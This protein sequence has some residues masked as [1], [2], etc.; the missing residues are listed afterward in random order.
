MTQLMRHLALGALLIPLFAYTYDNAHFY[1]AT[2]FFFEPRLERDYL[3]SVDLFF[4]AGS[5][6]KARN[7]FHDTVPLLDIYGTNDMHELAI[8]VPCKDLSNPLDMIITQLSLVPS[9]CETS[10]DACKTQSKFATFSIDGT[11][12]I[13]EGIISIAQN[14]K[15]GFFLQLYFPIRRLKI[16]SICTTDIS[17]TDEACPN[18]N[19]PIW[20]TFK[21]NFDDILARYNL[22]RCP[23][24]KTGIGDITFLLGWTHSFQQ[25][26]VLDFVDT[27]FK[28]GVLIPS[29]DQRCEDQVFS[30]PIGYDG[31]VA[32]VIDA[33][34]A[35]GAFDWLT[36]GGHFDLLVFANKT[37]CIRLKTGE[38][39]SGWFKLAKG[40]TKREKG[41]LWQIGAY[42]KADHFAHGLS[43]LLAYS[44]ASKNRDELT[45]CDTQEFCPAIVNNDQMLFSWKMHTLNFLLE[46]D[47]SKP[48]S[49]V[50]PRFSIYYN[51]VVGGKRIFTTGTGGGNIGV[52]IA[53]SF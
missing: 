6:K 48:K 52:D 37:K 23:V 19:T 26:E 32:A 51:L 40:E 17:P 46:Y 35:F 21:N 1:R 28:F 3:T 53:W 15:R 41:T 38:H 29:G 27:S 30:L 7:Q 10:T 18:I 34:F 50:G 13:I 5:T 12:S 49:T 14:I 2:N 39:Q 11:F 36:L 33:D 47:F 31:H 25:T 9:R 42:I 45:P 22:S 44:F 8:G 4:D 16:S 43:L 20:K 24:E